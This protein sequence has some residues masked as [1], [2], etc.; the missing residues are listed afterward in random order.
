[1]KVGHILPWEVGVDCVTIIVE[2]QR[3]TKYGEY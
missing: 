1:M 2:Y 3:L